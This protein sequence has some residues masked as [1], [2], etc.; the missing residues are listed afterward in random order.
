[1][2]LLGIIMCQSLELEF[3]N[4]LANDPDVSTVYVLKDKHSIGFSE[5]VEASR[6]GLTKSKDYIG[7]VFPPEEEFNVVVQC[8][9]V[10][11]HSVIA[12]LREGVKGAAMEMGPFVDAILL[13][14]GLCG[15][16][17]GNPRELLA[18]LHVPLFIPM[19][20]DHP[21]DDCV[22]L[23]I[24]GR[25]NYYEEQCKCAGTMFWTPGFARHWKEIF[26]EG[27]SRGYEPDM[28]KRLMRD[29]ERVL[30]I[31]SPVM[32]EEELMKSAEEFAERFGLRTET[33]SGSLEILQ[34]TW[35]QVKEYFRS[36]S[37]RQGTNTS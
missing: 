12:H 2:S 15:N 20:E 5:A 21:V 23:L 25:E 31:P 13:G 4:I 10:G 22:G 3:A 28:L 33:G 17:L 6:R 18:N 7:K 24:G 14:Y 27:E 16:A 35:L 9:R 34:R 26:R 19:D 8:M 30:L 36:V 29:Y 37:D 32:E 1:M 11:L